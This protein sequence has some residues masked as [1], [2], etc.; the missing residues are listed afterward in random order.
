MENNSKKKGRGG[1]MPG[2]GRPKSENKKNKYIQIRCTQEEKDILKEK[3]EKSGLDLSK[4]MLKTAIEK[5]V[6]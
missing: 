5:E 6:E 2:A 3:A 4:F 1:A